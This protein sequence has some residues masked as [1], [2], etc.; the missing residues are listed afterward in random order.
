MFN[1]S[2]CNYFFRLVLH[3][4]W[5]IWNQSYCN[6]YA[7][8]VCGPLPLLRVAQQIQSS[9][10]LP[11]LCDRFQ[12]SSAQQEDSDA[13]QAMCRWDFSRISRL[14]CFVYLIVFMC[15]IYVC[16]YVATLTRIHVTT[17]TYVRAFYPMYVFVAVFN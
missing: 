7:E 4:G 10:D 3:G 17:T 14:R 1:H 6:R 11:C 2:P 5:S 16:M 15:P 13:L 9:R 8:A 12:A